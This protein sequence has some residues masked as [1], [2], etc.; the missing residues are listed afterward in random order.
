MTARY[1]KT[2]SPSTGRMV[3]IRQIFA[4]QNQRVLFWLRVVFRPFGRH[5][6]AQTLV[7]TTCRDVGLPDLQ[8][9]APHP[10]AGGVDEHVMHQEEPESLTPEWKVDHQ[11]VDVQF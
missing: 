4:P 1:H 10:R 8:G 6:E 2:P 7:E 11:R 3:H 5:R 9:G